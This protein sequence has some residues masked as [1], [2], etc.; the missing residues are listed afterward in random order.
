MDALR[1]NHLNEFKELFSTSDNLR[2]L[3]LWNFKDPM[4]DISGEGYIDRDNLAAWLRIQSCRRIYQADFEVAGF[5]IQNTYGAT[6]P[7]SVALSHDRRRHLTSVL[8]HS[9][10]NDEASTI[11]QDITMRREDITLPILLPYLFLVSRAKSANTKLVD[12]T[13]EILKIERK[14]GIRVNFHPGKQCCSAQSGASDGRNLCDHVDFDQV[15]GDLT[16]LSSKL[17]YCEYI[18]EAFL[19]V[20]DS[21]EKNQ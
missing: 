20:L 17:A 5:M 10:P 7:S 19:L 8:V 12:G 9:L 6:L 14:T 1:R 18:C 16:S 11:I 2:Y 21:L 4:R 13:L 15:T 3:E